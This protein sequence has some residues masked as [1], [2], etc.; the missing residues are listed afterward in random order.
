MQ[1]TR[2]PPNPNDPDD[3]PGEDDEEP[4][5]DVNPR[6]PAASG[7]EV[8][9]RRGHGLP[10]SFL[11]TRFHLLRAT[12]AESKTTL[13]VRAFSGGYGVRLPDFDF[14]ALLVVTT[15]PFPLPRR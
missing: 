1:F 2:P 11:P 8:L 12:D 14:M 9:W 7:V 15:S 5:V 4:P 10:Q 6:A 3:D 13:P